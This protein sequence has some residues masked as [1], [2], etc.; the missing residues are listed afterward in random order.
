MADLDNI[1]KIITWEV[2]SDAQNVSIKLTK[3]IK[4]PNSN[5]SSPNLQIFFSS[6]LTWS[7]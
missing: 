6:N 2:I 7:G 4:G 5:L 3:Y 1:L